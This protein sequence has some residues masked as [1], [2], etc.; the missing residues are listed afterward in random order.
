MSTITIEMPDRILEAL[1]AH[2]LLEAIAVY[3]YRQGA[4]RQS[5]VGQLLALDNL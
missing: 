2:G 1:Q 3:G 5:Q 4:L